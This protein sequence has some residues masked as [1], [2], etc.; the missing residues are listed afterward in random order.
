MKFSKID[1]ISSGEGVFSWSSALILSILVIS[2]GIIRYYE[3]SFLS[4][5]GYLASIREYGFMSRWIGLVNSTYII[6][7]LQF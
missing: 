5:S 1:R 7:R 6:S 2:W 3:S 4:F